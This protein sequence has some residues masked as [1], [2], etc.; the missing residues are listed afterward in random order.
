MSHSPGPVT[1]AMQ[2][3]IDASTACET[4]QI[5]SDLRSF[6]EDPSVAAPSGSGGAGRVGGAKE[7]TVQCV[8]LDTATSKD[9]GSGGRGTHNFF[10]D[11]GRLR[12]HEG[13]KR[14]QCVGLGPHYAVPPPDSSEPQAAPRSQYPT[15][16]CRR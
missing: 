13:V 12:L 2:C 10:V 6:V 16:S 5:I 8:I 9:P 3:K 15:R 11:I 4:C 7:A 14:G 1:G